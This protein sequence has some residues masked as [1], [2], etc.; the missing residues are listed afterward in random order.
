MTMNTQNRIRIALGAAA[1]MAAVTTGATAAE[2]PKVHVKYQDLNLNTP[3]GAEALYRRI[4]TA[5]DEVCA[6]PGTRDLAMRGATKACAAH[7]M[8]NAVAQVNN[9]Q[10]TH[11][12]Q[13]KVA[14]TA[15]TRLAAR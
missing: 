9:P 3:A 4:L 2:L 13:A 11:V 10:L 1:L 8:A 14:G 5:A 7:A 12:D 15:V 6:I